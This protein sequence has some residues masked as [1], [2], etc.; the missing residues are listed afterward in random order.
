MFLDFLDHKD[1][2]SYKLNKSLL[3]KPQLT[4]PLNGPNGLVFTASDK[5]E[6]IADSL[7]C[8]FMKNPNP[9]VTKNYQYIKIS[10]INIFIILRTIQ[11]IIQNL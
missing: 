10:L 1:S 11:L 2:L 5:A 6:L 3:N 8:Q 4:Y 9:N 7:E